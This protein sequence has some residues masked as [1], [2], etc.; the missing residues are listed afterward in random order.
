MSDLDVFR[1][2]LIIFGMFIM[3]F[4]SKKIN[5]PFAVGE[6]LYGILIKNMFPINWH[7]SAIVNF[8]SLF[9]FIVLMYMAGLELDIRTLK[10]VTKKDAFAFVLYFFV[11]IGFAFFIAKQMNKPAIYALAFSVTSIGLLYPVLKEH[12]MINK[13]FGLK[14][15]ILGSIGEI[16]SLFAIIIF[17][18]YF[19]FGFSLESL[20]KLTQLAVFVILSILFLRLLRLFLW[21]FPHLSEIFLKTG[22]TTETGIR[23][24]FLNLIVFVFL[25]DILGIEP[26]LGAFISGLILSLSLQE[27][28][29]IKTS[30]GIIGNG[31]LVPIFFIHVGLSFDL[32]AMMSLNMI[33]EACLVAIVIVLVRYMSSF[34]LLLSDFKL[35]EVFIAPI[36]ISFPL[37]LLVAVSQFGKSFG[38]LDAKGASMLVLSAMLTSFIYSNVFK[39]IP[40]R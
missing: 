27:N 39:S 21:W 6:I 29:N 10:N 25:S 14:I 33:K 26:I 11:V 9:G 13:P 23:T 32:S 19:K 5:I 35:K 4:I 18:L 28:E 38:I 31:F 1:L 3:P 24:N 8:L 40:L 7:N 17:N 34:V 37:T 16:M 36:G 20:I 2:L 15:L 12:N 22:N 30:F